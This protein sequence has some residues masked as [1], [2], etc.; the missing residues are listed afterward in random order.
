MNA[1]LLQAV[2][3]VWSPSL[4]VTRADGD[5]SAVLRRSPSELAD[6]P[7]HVAL[8]TTPDRARDNP[9]KR[10]EHHGAELAAALRALGG[11]DGAPPA[12]ELRGLAPDLDVAALT[13]P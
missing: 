9:Q 12:P 2:Q 8:G 4:R 6:A 3:L 1:P 13:T 7:L 5:C 11:S 10:M